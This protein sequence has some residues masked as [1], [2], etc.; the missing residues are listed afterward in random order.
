MKD[1]IGRAVQD[2]YR[3]RP[4]QHLVHEFDFYWRH[5]YMIAIILF[6]LSCV[7]KD[8]PM[9]RIAVERDLLIICKINSSRKG[10]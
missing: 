9:G 6:A 5:G 4:L 7:D 1:Y 10:F 3:F 8:L 2:T